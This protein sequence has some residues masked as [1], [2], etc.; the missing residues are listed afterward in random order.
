LN[1]PE[2][3]RTALADQPVEGAACLEAGAGVGNTTAGLLDVGASRVYAVANAREDCETV[4]KR[5]DDARATVLEAD[6]R[7]TPLADDSVDLV[8]AHGLCNV[9]PPAALDAVA[10]ELTRVARPGA[11]LVVDDY[12]PLPE[13]AA[14]REL[15]AVENAATE[16]ADGRPALTFYPA[17]T[18]VRLFA[19]HGWT[20]ERKRT[21]LEPVPWTESHVSAHA[22]VARSAADRLGDDL[23]APLR[24]RARTLAE[25]IGSEDA[26]RMYSLALSL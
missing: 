14:M 11:R 17:E 12:D 6:L 23:A 19:G 2:T 8:T 4:R 5:I 26:G 25:A 20:V 22:D 3:V 9:L 10:A 7:A 1:I 15:F 24:E 13:N 16:L 18:L 21:L